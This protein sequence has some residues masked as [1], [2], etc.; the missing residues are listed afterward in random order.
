MKDKILSVGDTVTVKSELYL[1][2]WIKPFCE[3]VIVRIGDSEG[4]TIY[5]VN[6]GGKQYS[7]V[8]GEL[9]EMSQ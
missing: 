2:H 3:G 6:I 9:N 8:R 5:H 1:G 7:F 4:Q